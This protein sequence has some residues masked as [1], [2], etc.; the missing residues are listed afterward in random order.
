MKRKLALLTAVLLLISLFSGCG[1]NSGTSTTPTQTPTNAP[2]TPNSGG[3]QP[4]PTEAP[5]PYNLAAGKYSVD[6][7]GVPLEKY[8]YELPLTTSDETFSYWISPVLPD[9]IDPDHYADMP[10]PA[11]LREK[12]GVH[13]EYMLIAAQSKAENF[14]ALLATDALPD[15]MS[16]YRSY[17]PTTLLNSIEDGFSVNLY[18]YREYMPNYY[19]EIWSH[20]DD[21]NVRGKLMQNDHTIAVF[22]C[23]NSECIISYGGCVRG[24][25]IDKLGIRVDDIITIDNLHDTISAF[26]TQ[27]GVE[28]PFVLLNVL[29]AHRYMSCFDT[30]CY[31]TGTVAPVLQKDGKVMFACCNDGDRDYMTTMNAWYNEGF[32]SPNWLNWSGNVTFASDFQTNKVGVTSMLPSEAAG[33]VD[34]ESTPEAYWMA[35]HQPSRYVGQVFHLGHTAS[36]LQGIGHWGLSAKCENIPLLV[37]YCD[38]FYSDEGIFCANWGKEGYT[39][40]Y[41]E[42]GQPQLTDFI[43]NNVSGSAW[44]IL[45]FALNDVYEGGI[46]LRDRSYSIP[47]GE[48]LRAWYDIWND[49]EYYRYDG[50]MEFPTSITYS[51]EDTAYLANVGT[52]IQTFLGE[53]YL[54]FVDNSRSL[55]EWDSYVNTLTHLPGWED[56]KAIY[57]RYYDDFKAAHS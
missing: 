46:L 11:Y 3:N 8:H 41:N 28:H 21:V 18:D 12:T 42:S 14:A 13:I 40:N 56:A 23:M 26:Q 53:N 9:Q 4:A 10:Y 49:P 15:L 37:T 29:D 36:W 20:E 6:S 7:R 17:Y 57:Q 43:V 44:A 45:Q 30:H 39:F 55:S 1:S 48:K 22:E 51:A 52:D 16:N 31:T 25:W 5:G 32:I 47:G 34:L 2:A 54:Q 19:H 38:W 50:S 27:L 33:Y 35:I 24:D